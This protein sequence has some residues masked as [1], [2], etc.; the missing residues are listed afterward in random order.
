MELQEIAFIEYLLDTEHL[1]RYFICIISQGKKIMNLVFANAEFKASVRLSR[2][3]YQE[4]VTIIIIY[5][6]ET[7]TQ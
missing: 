4:I 2:K 3:A 7:K 1:V 5:R 6:K